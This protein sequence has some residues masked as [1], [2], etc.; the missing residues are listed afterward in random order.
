MSVNGEEV[1]LFNIDGQYFA[2]GNICP[3]KGGSLGEGFTDGDIITCPLH[4]WRFNVKTG[5]NV[6][7]PSSRIQTYSVKIEG[8]DILVSLD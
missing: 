7:I 2:T 3:H 1:A 5:Q 4:G 6:F 8:Q